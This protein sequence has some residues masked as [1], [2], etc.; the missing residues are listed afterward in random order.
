MVAEKSAGSTVCPF[1]PISWGPVV[2]VDPAKVDE[3]VG[4]KAE[5]VVEPEVVVGAD[6]V[7]DDGAGVVVGADEVVSGVD[8][9]PAAAGRAAMSSIAAAK[10]TSSRPGGC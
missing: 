2:E 1:A 9:Q 4:A 6:V 10:P 5:V 3:V 8:A 7:V